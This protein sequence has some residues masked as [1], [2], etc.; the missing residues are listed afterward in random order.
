[1]PEPSTGL[2]K[3]DVQT[4]AK[5]IPYGISRFHNT[6]MVGCS[7]LKYGHKAA[8]SNKNV[9]TDND[10]NAILINAEQGIE[11]KMPLKLLPADVNLGNIITMTLQRNPIAEKKRHDE[12]L[13][14][15]QSFLNDPYLYNNSNF[16]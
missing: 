15:Q 16:Y 11:I 1:M 13:S 14:I 4:R 12:L 8:E 5:R 7:Q 9:Q 10:V 2:E 3:P 6:N